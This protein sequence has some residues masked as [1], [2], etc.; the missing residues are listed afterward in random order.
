[1]QGRIYEL[2]MYYSFTRTE[3]ESKNCIPRGDLATLQEERILSRCVSGKRS[4]LQAM[5][6]EA[7]VNVKGLYLLALLFKQ[8]QD[9]D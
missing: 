4:K 7:L 6:S 9:G 1:M 5:G 8:A 2:K 3:N